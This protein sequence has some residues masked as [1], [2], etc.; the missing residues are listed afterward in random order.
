M[1]F[2]LRTSS[3][4][5]INSPIECLLP[6]NLSNRNYSLLSPTAA[7]IVM[8]SKPPIKYQAACTELKYSRL[9]EASAA[10][11][12]RKDNS[13]LNNSFKATE[14][15]HDLAKIRKKSQPLPCKIEKKYQNALHKENKSRKS[16]PFL[17][18]IMNRIYKQSSKMLFSPNMYE[19]PSHP[20]EPIQEK[21]LSSIIIES[22]SAEI[23]YKTADASPHAEKNIREEKIKRRVIYNRGSSHVFHESKDI[24]DLS[25]SDSDNQINI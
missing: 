13:F 4:I 3:K 22:P 2:K 20:D 21:I 16:I 1:F 14:R 9:I 12:K 15:F 6:S 18:E 24:N 17:S 7:D 11:K 10:A 8:S 23:C 25:D 19:N 5:V